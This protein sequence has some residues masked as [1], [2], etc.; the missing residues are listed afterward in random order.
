MNDLNPYNPIRF[1]K[2][3]A[4]LFFMMSF[5]FLLSAFCLSV[6]NIF[7]AIAYIGTLQ[8]AMCLIAAYKNLERKDNGK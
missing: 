7:L 8:L 4:K 1:N 2:N 5:W 6:I 3:E